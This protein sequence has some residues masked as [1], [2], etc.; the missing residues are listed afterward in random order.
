MTPELFRELGSIGIALVLILYIFKSIYSLI[1]ANKNKSE[2]LIT[3]TEDADLKN[4]IAEIE[5]RLNSII[6][7]DAEWRIKMSED[8]GAI[9]GALEVCKNN[10]AWMIKRMQNGIPK[11]V[12]END[13][14]NS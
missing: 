2:V 6:I 3:E 10:M 1:S 11:G 7:N 9:R 5:R 12:M 8:I 4:R 14:G 13:I